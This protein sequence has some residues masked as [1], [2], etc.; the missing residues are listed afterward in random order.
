MTVNPTLEIGEQKEKLSEKIAEQK[1]IAEEIMNESD[2]Y[3]KRL[4][5][6]MA[7]RGIVAKL[8]LKGKI[9]ENEIRAIKTF[10]RTEQ[11]YG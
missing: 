4:Q 6:A 5:E 1:Q 10:L 7:Q 11:Q 8:K 3:N 9:V 2:V